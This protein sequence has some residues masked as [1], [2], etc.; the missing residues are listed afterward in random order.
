MRAVS[1][2]LFVA[3]LFLGQVTPL[4]AEGAF[5]QGNELHDQCQRNGPSAW[6]TL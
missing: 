1:A 2:A 3:L 5:I 6:A 4:R